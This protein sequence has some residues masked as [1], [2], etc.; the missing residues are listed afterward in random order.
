ME[1][2]KERYYAL[3]RRAYDLPEDEEPT[4][5][6]LAKFA[7][8]VVQAEMFCPDTEKEVGAD[9]L[10]M[11]KKVAKLNKRSGKVDVTKLRKL[12]N[13]SEQKPELV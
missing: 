7:H 10:A 4:F 9:V 3:V 8:I 5:I 13:E 12:L 11:C 2:L 6:E 1:T